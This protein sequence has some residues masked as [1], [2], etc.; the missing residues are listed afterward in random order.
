MDLTIVG[1]CTT[2]CDAL[3]SSVSTK[4]FWKKVRLLLLTESS[5]LKFKYLRH[6]TIQH[7]RQW[8]AHPIN[9]DR[10]TNGEF[11]R[12]YTTLREN[13]NKFRQ[14]FRMSPTTFDYILKLI[15]PKMN[16][17]WSNFIRHPISAEE[18]L[19]ITVR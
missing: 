9:S 8:S 12:L 16:I 7:K 10:V 5:Y 6:D 13:P 15:E 14:Y 17:R 18:R 2:R 19:M 11:H 3:R 4:M 1:R